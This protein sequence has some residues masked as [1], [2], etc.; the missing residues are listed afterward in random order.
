MNYSNFKTNFWL[1]MH[2][3]IL[4]VGMVLFSAQ[5][6]SK[7]ATED[8]AI[9]SVDEQRVM[10]L[11]AKA[12]K[13]VEKNG[14]D[15]VAEF[16][17]SAEFIDNELY[18][19]AIRV[20]GLFLASGGSSMVLKGDLV[21]HTPDAFGQVFFHRIIEKAIADGEGV[22]E[23]Y[24]TNPVSRSNKPKRTL[25]KRV[26]DVI[27]AVGYHPAGNTSIKQIGTLDDTIIVMMSDKK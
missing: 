18:V 9:I 7:S 24:W 26:G 27:V 19:F 16:D 21:W 11:L 17:S 15:S 12:V 25:F 8:N 13:H 5:A 3:V 2:L 6:N 10:T 23:Y 14:P 1:Q 20:D 22:V 4:L